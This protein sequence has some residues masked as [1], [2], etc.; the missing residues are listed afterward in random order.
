MANHK[1]T[2]PP[3]AM[4]H[5]HTAMLSTNFS[6]HFHAMKFLHALFTSLWTNAVALIDHPAEAPP[7]P[8]ARAGDG[9]ARNGTRLMI[10]WAPGEPMP[11]SLSFDSG[12]D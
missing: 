1:T 11:R 3:K 7:S 2:N 8:G 9:T 10:A 6:A 4:P 5:S 12:H